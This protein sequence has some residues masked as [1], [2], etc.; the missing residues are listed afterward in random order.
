MI[1]YGCSGVTAAIRASS[2]ARS[3]ARPRSRSVSS[4]I[5]SPTSPDGSTTMI[6]SSAGRFPRTS[7]IFATCD[8]S[9]QTIARDS[10]LP[11]THSHSSGELVG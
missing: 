4:G 9:S 11:A 1:V 7:R 10:E 6:V 5:A 8:A 2:S 3:R